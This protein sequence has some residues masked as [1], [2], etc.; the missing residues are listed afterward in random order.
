[1]RDFSYRRAGSP[2]E[3][4]QA[5]ATTGAMLLAGGTTLLDPAFGEIEK[6]GPAGQQHCPCGGGRSPGFILR[7]G[8]MIGEIP[9]GFASAEIRAASRTAATIWG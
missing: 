6:G 8:A 9:H 1:M 2:D 5:A 7:A 4:R 3:A